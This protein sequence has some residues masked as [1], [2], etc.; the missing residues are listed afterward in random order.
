VATY[1]N[2]REQSTLSEPL[3]EKENAD[4][5]TDDKDKEDPPNCSRDTS[6]IIRGQTVTYNPI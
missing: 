4:E 3:K 6:I 1:A 5:R 2:L